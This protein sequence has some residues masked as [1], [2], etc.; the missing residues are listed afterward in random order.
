MKV[1]IAGAGLC[2]LATAHRLHEAGL[3]VTVL[4]GN[5]I[6]GGRVQPV[7]PALQAS[8]MQQ[9]LGPSW[10]WPYAQANVCKWFEVL[11]IKTFAQFDAGDALIDRDPNDDAQRQFLPGQHGIARVAGGTYAIV[12]SLLEKLPDV[13]HYRQTVTSCDFGNSGSRVEVCVNGAAEPLHCHKLILALPP[14]LAVPLIPAREALSGVINVMQQT[15]T[16]MAQHAKVV[17]HFDDAFWRSNGLSGRVASQV[18]PLV[19]IHDHCGPDGSPAALFG[20]VGL[21]AAQR[22]HMGVDALKAAV[23]EQLSRCFGHNSPAPCEI[24]VK[25]WALEELT[26][27]SADLADAGS[28]P[29]VVS[30]LVRK[31]WCDDR[32]WFAGSET[33]AISPGLIDGA[34]ARADQVADDIIRLA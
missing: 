19:E 4:E 1:I 32:L 5:A 34:F 2:G 9:D 14:R 8:E 13:V 33:S 7:S 29:A 12:R 21:S 3:D 22:A 17:I 28:H 10:V 11:D 27:T 15:P 30:D 31:P 23:R 25:D 26:S 16:W 20:F 18:G 24:E 6:A